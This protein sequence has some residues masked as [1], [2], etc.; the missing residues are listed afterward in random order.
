MTRPEFIHGLH[1]LLPN[2]HG[3]VATIGSFDG[4]HRGHQEVIRQLREHASAHQVPALVMVFEPQPSEFFS[5]EKAP[6]RLMR[7]RDKTEALFAAGVDRVLC[8]RFNRELRGLSAQAFIEQVLVARL[9]IRHLVIGDDFRFGCDRQGDYSMLAAAG[10]RFGFSVCDTR[11]ELDGGQRI[12]STRIRAL[13]EQDAFAEAARLLGYEYRIRGR[14]IYGKQLGRT[15]GFPTANVHLGRY[16]T[17]V[18]GVYA[19]AVDIDGG[20]QN[21]PA[22]ANIGVRPTVSG[23]REPLLEVHLLEHG[24]NLYGHWINVRIKHKLRSEMRF[25]S[26]AALQAQITLDVEIAKRWFNETH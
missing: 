15:L 13:L 1:S 24:G 22:V 19:V 26:L 3:C 6:P 25:E 7:L 5:Q 23:G 8:L 12:S 14:V 2:H 21:V 11:T 16:R 18:Q 10:E 9:G 20:A 17:A 4:V